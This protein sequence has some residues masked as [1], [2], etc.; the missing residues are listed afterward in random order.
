MPSLSASLRASINS[1]LNDIIALHE[2]LL[3]DLHRL[4]P[5]SEY[6]QLSLSS[7]PN[8]RSSRRAAHSRWKSLDAV[9][10]TST[11]TNWLKGIPGMTAE[12]SIAAEVA[13]AFVR[14]VS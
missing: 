11:H 2:D 8:D 13:K 12:P 14:R 9:A 3:G 10:E 7:I 6:T 1:N 4:V 5:H